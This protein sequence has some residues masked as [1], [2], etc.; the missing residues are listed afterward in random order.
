M[1]KARERKTPLT[2]GNS[3]SH[4]NP[5]FSPF[6]LYDYQ[7]ASLPR[8]RRRGRSRE[9]SRKA[10]KPNTSNSQDEQRYSQQKPK[11]NIKRAAPSPSRAFAA[12]NTVHRKGRP[13][14]LACAFRKNAPTFLTEKLVLLLLARQ[15]AIC[16][17]VRQL[18]LRAV[19][20]GPSRPPYP[21]YWVFCTKTAKSWLKRGKLG[22]IRIFMPNPWQNHRK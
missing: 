9:A 5:P 20:L 12:E 22:K 3:R 8:G 11:R 7:L 6:N 15:V 19:R 14:S 4:A 18:R 16:R 2:V 1:A 10:K 21:N 13:N 17:M